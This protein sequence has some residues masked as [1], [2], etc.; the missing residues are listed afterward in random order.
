MGGSN[1]GILFKFDKYY[2][3]RIN[4]KTMRTKVSQKT[5]TLGEASK[6]MTIG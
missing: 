3:I 4:G 2:E 1:D 6:S 5:T